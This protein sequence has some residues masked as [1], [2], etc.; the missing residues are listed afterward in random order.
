M[1]ECGC[2]ARS[3]GPALKPIEEALEFLLERVKPVRDV[4]RVHTESALGR[5]SAEPVVASREAVCRARPAGSSSTISK[6][7]A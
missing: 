2:D 3:S 6:S 4:E 1:S 5:V 7:V